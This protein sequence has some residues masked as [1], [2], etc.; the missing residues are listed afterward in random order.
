MQSLHAEKKIYIIEIPERVGEKLNT[1]LK[2]N[3]VI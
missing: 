1:K 2:Y 3:C